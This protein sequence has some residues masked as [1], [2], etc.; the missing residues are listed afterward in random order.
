MDGT[1]RKEIAEGIF[2]HL[3]YL[4]NYG[5]LY[6]DQGQ[7]TELRALDLKEEL[8]SEIQAIQAFEDQVRIITF[9]LDHGWLSR[10]REQA[11]QRQ[12]QKEEPSNG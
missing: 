5:Q 9:K 1:C 12:K 6:A 3:I 10:L 2:F 11:Y 8:L 4:Q 7:L